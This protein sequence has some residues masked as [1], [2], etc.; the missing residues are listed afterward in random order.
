[1]EALTAEIVG[2]VYIPGAFQKK[3]EPLMRDMITFF[4]IIYLVL[5]MATTIHGRCTLM[6]P[7]VGVEQVSNSW[8]YQVSTATKSLLHFLLARL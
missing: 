4:T 2:V 5:V 3:L 7:I 6:S 8:D 1:M